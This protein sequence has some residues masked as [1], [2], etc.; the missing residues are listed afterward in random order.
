MPTIKP[1]L[2]APVGSV[3]AVASAGTAQQPPPAMLPAVEVERTSLAQRNNDPNDVTVRFNRWHA[4][5][6]S[7]YQK[8]QFAGFNRRVAQQLIASGVAVLA[9]TPQMRSQPVDRFVSK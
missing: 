8:G 9:E 4:H 2:D 1:G 7:A 6:S 3:A 5:G